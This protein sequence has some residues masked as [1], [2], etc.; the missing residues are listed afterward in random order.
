MMMKRQLF[1][2]RMLKSEV[3]NCTGTLA[4][5]GGRLLV[6]SKRNPSIKRIESFVSNIYQFSSKHI[7]QHIL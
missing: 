2:G 7:C 6:L 3:S 4:V 5:A 1:R